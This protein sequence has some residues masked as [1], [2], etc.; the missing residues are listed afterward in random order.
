LCAYQP[1][2]K[3]FFFLEKEMP[4]TSMKMN[5]KTMP[6]ILF[7][8]NHVCQV[9]GCQQLHGEGEACFTGNAKINR[10]RGTP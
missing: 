1:Q 4:K 10:M 6:I 2:Q 9:Y 3:K 5:A 8:I 7:E